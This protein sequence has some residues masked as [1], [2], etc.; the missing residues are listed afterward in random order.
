MS[1]CCSLF[2][3]CYIAIHII[4]DL[5]LSRSNVYMGQNFSIQIAIYIMIQTVLLHVSQGGIEGGLEIWS[6][7]IRTTAY[8]YTRVVGKE[9]IDGGIYESRT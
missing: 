5:T 3:H 6:A 2:I 7:L 9:N 4:S 1:N 8:S